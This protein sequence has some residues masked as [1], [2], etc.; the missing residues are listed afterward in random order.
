MRPQ[1][2]HQCL[3]SPQG[4]ATPSSPVCCLQTHSLPLCAL[5][6]DRQEGQ[7]QGPCPLPSSSE[8]CRAA[9]AR[10][11]VLIPQAASL[12]GLHRLAAVLPG[13]Q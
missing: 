1:Y 2:L 9:G 13:W 7:Q 8:G 3:A 10:G 4:K 5:R 6:A 11:P 12:Q